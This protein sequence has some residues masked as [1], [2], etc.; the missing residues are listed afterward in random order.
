MPEF[1][2][3]DASKEICLRPLAERENRPKAVFNLVAGAGIA[4]A[5]QGYEPREGL[6]LNPAATTFHKM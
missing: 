5:Y 1:V 2:S 4:P 6:L 3:P